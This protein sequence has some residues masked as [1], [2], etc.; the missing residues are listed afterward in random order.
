M[1]TRLSS[2]LP[3]RF[4]AD[5]SDAAYD[6]WGA[7]CGPHSIAAACGETLV[8]MRTALPDFRGFMSPTEINRA[9]LVLCKNANFK[10]RLKT[11]TLCNGINRIQWEG[12]WLN[13]GVP[14]RVAYFHTHYVAHFDGWVLCTAQVPWLWLSIEE[15]NRLTTDPWHITHHWEMRAPVAP[16]LLNSVPS[17]PPH[18]A[19]VTKSNP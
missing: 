17:V 9:L 12:K 16:E 1:R 18:S 13:P 5:D 19:S 4:T 3:L 14:P 7:N 8:A 11:K 6:Q 2:P 10:S 15:W